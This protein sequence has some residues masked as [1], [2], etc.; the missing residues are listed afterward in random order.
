MDI[1]TVDYETSAIAPRPEYPPKPVGVAI[2]T[3]DG[4]SEYLAW[5]HPEKNNTKE[6][7]AVYQLEALWKEAASENIRL[8]FH[9]AKFDIDVGYEHHGFRSETEGRLS[10]CRWG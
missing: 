10:P 9:N 2:R 4:H 1:V 7:K 6:D 8:L 3:P 5:G